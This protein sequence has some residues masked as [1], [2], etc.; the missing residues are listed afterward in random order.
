MPKTDFHDYVVMD[1]MNGIRG[2]RSRAMFGGWGLYKNDKIFGIIAEDEVY[3][4]VGDANCKDYEERGSEPFTYKAKGRKRVSLSYWR[5]P[6]DILEDRSALEEW[7]EK[8]CRVKK[9]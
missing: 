4:K 6:A 5:V 2:I 3:F 7:V 9:T 1:L 8:S